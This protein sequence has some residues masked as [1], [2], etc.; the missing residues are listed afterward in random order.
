MNLSGAIA[1]V[2]SYILNA[3]SST[4]NEEDEIDIA[5]SDTEEFLDKAL[6]TIISKATST[7]TDEDRK[8]SGYALKVL[9]GTYTYIWG[10]R[11]TWDRRMG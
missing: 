10:A 5:D 4:G 8:K 2:E 11:T 9:V 7:L 3:A 6:G 1:R